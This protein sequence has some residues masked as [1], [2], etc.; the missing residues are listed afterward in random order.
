MCMARPLPRP[1]VGSLF[2]VF[3]AACS[4]DDPD[5]TG[6]PVDDYGDLLDEAK[7]E[8][9][10]TDQIVTCGEEACEASLCGYDCSDPGQLCERSC[11]D[12][13]S[14]ADAFVEFTASGGHAVTR[15]SRDVPYEPVLRLDDVLFYGCELWDFAGSSK[16]G[17]ELRFAEIFQGAFTPSDPRDHGYELNVYAAPF[18]GPGTYTAEGFLSRSDDARDARDYWYGED[19]CQMQ[20]EASGDGLSG[21]FRCAAIPH[22][23]GAA[24]V[25]LSGSFACGANSLDIRIIDLLRQPQ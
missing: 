5:R 9:A 11:A 16:Q 17:L 3:L 6:E 4:A 21:T 2:L 15:D 14:R 22:R 19:A 10:K 8:G 23:S 18:T 13:D 7:D 1:L 25:A 20:V 12:A 24:S